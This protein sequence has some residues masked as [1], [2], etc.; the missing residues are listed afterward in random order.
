MK[1]LFFAG[2]IAALL[3]AA[4]GD[5][6][7]KVEEKNNEVATGQTS[8]QADWKSEI[9]KIASNSDAVADK[10]NAIEA[11]MMSY[12]DRITDAEVKQFTSDIIDDYK[13]RKYLSELTN[14]ERMLTNIFKSYIVSEKSKDQAT[15]D[16]AFDYFQNMKYTYRGVDA[17]YSDAV[18]ANEGQMD[19]ALKQIK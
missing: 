8:T 17:V 12:R 5:E 10:Y 6:E 7:S 4:C 18:K 19:K 9:N 1:K 16:F 15:I 11:Y 2:A 14:H 3:L 13:S